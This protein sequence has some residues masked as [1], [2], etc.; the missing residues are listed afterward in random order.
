MKH[1]DGES[2]ITIYNRITYD[3]FNL[4]D[5]NISFYFPFKPLESFKSSWK[6]YWEL[7]MLLK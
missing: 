7:D 6:D 4:C 2:L 1:T 3:S 5:F